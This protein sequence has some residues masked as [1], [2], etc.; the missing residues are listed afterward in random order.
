M[1]LHLYFDFHHSLNSNE[2]ITN[3]TQMKIL[4]AIRSLQLRN[5]A[6]KSEKK[7]SNHVPVEHHESSNN[8]EL[9]HK[10][11]IKRNEGLPDRDTRIGEVSGPRATCGVQFS[12]VSFE[13]YVSRLR[14]P[15]NHDTVLIN[16]I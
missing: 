13:R 11:P 8:V 6:S 7:M 1:I 14:A 3:Y 2:A 4:F 10:L 16:G 9:M 12:Y 15:L 5:R